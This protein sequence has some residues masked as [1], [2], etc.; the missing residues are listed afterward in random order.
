MERSAAQ[1]YGFPDWGL[2][3]P[4][5]DPLRCEPRFRTLVERL[6]MVDPRFEQVCGG[7]NAP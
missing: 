5:V 2:V 3:M 6:G 1:R 4:G 7:V